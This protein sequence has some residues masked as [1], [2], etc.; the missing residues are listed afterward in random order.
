MLL[1]NSPAA[2]LGLALVGVASAHPSYSNA[3]TSSNGISYTTEIVTEIVTYCPSPTTIVQNHKTYTVTEPTTLTITD[4]PCTVTKP[5]VAPPPMKT[6]ETVTKYIE[7]T[8]TKEHTVTVFDCPTAWTK[9]SAFHPQPGHNGY[10]TEVVSELTTYCPKPTTLT[11]NGKTY[12][13]TE[14]TT[15][16]IT[17]CPCTV[18]KPAPTVT[19]T[20][21]IVPTLTTYCPHPTTITQG[22]KTYTV[23]APTTLTITDC[24]CTVTKPITKTTVTLP[25]TDTV[26]KPTETP[27]S[28]TWSPSTLSTWTT[29]KSSSSQTW[30]TSKTTQTS[31]TWETSETPSSYESTTET[32]GTEST[33]ASWESSTTSNTWGEGT[34]TSETWSQPSVTTTPGWEYRRRA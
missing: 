15:L 12:P 14:A 2:F 16:T 26:T 4:C 11:Y 17:D 33:T 22:T 25:T 20:T 3:T 5:V 31:Q 34:T 8:V 21:E 9:P 32:W 7:H 27:G 1:A 29:P 18:V 24:P 28:S 19:Y 10:V 23:T 13:V 6:P 30:Q